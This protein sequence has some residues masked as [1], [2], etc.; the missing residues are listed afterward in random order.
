MS[1]DKEM[2]LHRMVYDY[3]NELKLTKAAKTFKKECGTDMDPQH[4][5]RSLRRIFRE[6]NDQ[7]RLVLILLLYPYMHK[8][9]LFYFSFI[10]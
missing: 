6:A 5:R 3:L 1:Q 7:E 2:E 8:L 4:E 10:F 9:D